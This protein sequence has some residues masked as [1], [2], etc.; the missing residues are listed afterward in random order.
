MRE[1]ADSFALHGCE[2]VS[3]QD[4]DSKHDR[5]HG[6]NHHRGTRRWNG[7]R[8]LRCASTSTESE[9][10][11]GEEKKMAGTKTFGRLRH[12]Y[13]YSVF[14]VRVVQLFLS[15][16]VP[17][18]PDKAHREWQRTAGRNLMRQFAWS[19]S[20]LHQYSQYFVLCRW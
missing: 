7:G 17:A 10:H 15:R 16:R 4:V 5:G 12:E 3:F 14:D 6:W 1:Q 8:R 20:S 18:G 9:G 19:R 13:D 11:G 2:P